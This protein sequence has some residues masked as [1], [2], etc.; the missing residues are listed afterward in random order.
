MAYKTFLVAANLNIAPE[1]MDL[2]NTLNDVREIKRLLTESPSYFQERDV[3]EFTG[4]I[5]TKGIITSA[6]QSYFESATED[7]VLILFWAGHGY[8]HNGEGYLVPY[9]GRTNNV[10]DSMIRM[11]TVRNWI[12]QS[13]AKAVIAFFDTCHSGSIVR[14][15]DILRGLEITGTGKVIIAACEASQF[16]HD[17]NGHGAF[18]DYL[19]QGLSGA[20]ANP[21]GVIDVYTLYSFITNKLETEY[22]DQTP[23]FSTSTLNGSPIEIKRI[24]HRE[25]QTTTSY[26]LEVISNS[27][28]SFWLG[29]ICDEFNCFT[30]VSQGNYKM[31]IQNPSPTVENEIRALNEEKNTVVFAIRNQASLVRVVNLNVTTENQ[32]DIIEIDLEKVKGNHEVSMPGL[33]YGSLNGNRLSDD[34]IAELR[35]KRILSCDTVLQDDIILESLITRPTNSSIKLISPN[36][37]K[38]LQDKNYSP[39]RIRVLT[40]G[41]LIL[42]GTVEHI[43]HLNFF[44][45][46]GKMT[47]ID[48]IGIRKKYYKNVE[49]YRIALSIDI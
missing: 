39:T 32:V 44:M 8:L 41:H 2:P 49:A 35:A 21:N 45:Q 42:S 46:E 28:T 25:Q 1:C 10:E 6:L 7:D 13:S 38:D 11:T 17:R 43:E 29:K 12:N 16:A 37:I 36:L 18:T 26:E 19:I 30:E 33:A 5:V 22:L 14:G 23:T 40:I 27:G 15:Q 3:Q 20:A 24:I 47:K 48:F 4:N 34:E 9:E 31:V